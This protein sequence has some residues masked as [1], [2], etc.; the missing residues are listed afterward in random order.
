MTGCLEVPSLKRSSTWCESGVVPHNHCGLDSGPETGSSSDAALKLQAVYNYPFSF[1]SPG[2]GTFLEQGDG[3]ASS[4]SPATLHV[5]ELN[6]FRASP[7]GTTQCLNPFCGHGR[8]D[9]GEYEWYVR[10]SMS[11]LTHTASCD[12][13]APSNL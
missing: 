7:A 13:A 11:P 1:F 5:W 3:C 10:R 9:T 12:G 2:G 8:A 4:S 6:H